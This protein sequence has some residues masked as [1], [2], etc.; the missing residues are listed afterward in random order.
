M[1]LRD[2]RPV[3][4]TR[5]PPTRR[6]ARSWHSSTA[7]F[8]R[9]GRACSGSRPSSSCTTQAASSTRVRC[10]RP[11]TTPSPVAVQPF[12][13]VVVESHPAL[14]G[15]RLDALHRRLSPRGGG[16]ARPRP[17]GGDGARDGAP[18]RAGRAAQA[19]HARAVRRGGRPPCGDSAQTLRVFLLVGVP[20]VPRDEQ[21]TWMRQSVGRRSHAGGLG[22]L[23]DPDAAAA[24]ARCRGARGVGRF[25][26]P[27]ARRCRVLP[28]EAALPLGRARTRPGT[29]DVRV[30]A[31]LWDLDRLAS[32]PAC[33]PSRRARLGG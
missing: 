20:F 33:A 24:M 10:P 15:H 8:G 12:R 1:A 22:G 14:V 9:D 16:A 23:T 26:A 13:R 5:P 30:F 6:P 17:R 4:C 3:A 32:C 31:D 18:A 11:T 21:A 19:L 29:R 25:V 27:L 28:L 7:A 2:V